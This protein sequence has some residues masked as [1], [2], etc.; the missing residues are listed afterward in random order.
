MERIE[1]ILN[2]ITPLNHEV[3][4]RTGAY[5]DQLTKPVGSL[6]KLEEIAIQLAGITGNDY[7]DISAPAALVFAGD[8]GIVAEG[9]SAYPQEV[10]KLMIHNFLNGGAA[11][12]V[13]TRQINAT[14]H[15]IDVGVNGE[16]EH[17]Q[18]ISRKVRNGTANFLREAAM[19]TD[20]AIESILVGMEEAEKVIK[21]G[22]NILI[23]G[24]M[25]I[26]NTTASSALVAAFTDVSVNDLVGHGT[27][28]DEKGRLQKAEVI[29]EALAFHQPNEKD[30]IDAFTK[31]GGLEIGAMAGAMLKAASLKIPVLVDGFISA[32]AALLAYKLCPLVKEYLF[33][34]H[35][36]VEAG[37]RA[38]VKMLEKEPLLNLHLRLGE[39]TG[40]ALAY[41]ILDASTRM[42]REMATFADIGIEK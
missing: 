6:G 17:P 19:T 31:V 34:S 21:T 4:E 9:V 13:F 1:N 2:R 36:S 39:G 15:V 37:Q 33:I 25:G 32:T 35:Q 18:L 27:G 12:N 22:S 7:P 23:I 38:A 26:G 28:L 3:M 30:P 29:N 10:T 14:V 16:I 5:I 41:P 20:E 42:V 24:E 11:I 8:H 40:A